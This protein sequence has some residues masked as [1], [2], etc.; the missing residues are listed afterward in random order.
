MNVTAILPALLDRSRVVSLI[1]FLMVIRC[2]F[3]LF[4]LIWLSCVKRL[5][6]A[7]DLA[8]NYSLI[9]WFDF[10][11]YCVVCTIL[12]MLWRRPSIRTQTF[13]GKISTTCTTSLVSS[14][15]TSSSL[16]LTKRSQE[17][18][19][20][21]NI[22][23]CFS[24]VRVL[25]QVVLLM[26]NTMVSWNHQAALEGTAQ[27]PSYVVLSCVLPNAKLWTVPIMKR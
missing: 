24:S 2:T 21:L 18:K 16:A 4:K 12:H 9:Q 20:L 3:V 14:Q 15:L 25:T 19:L 17:H 26:K 11:Y 5:M 1:Q 13:T 8:L 6:L 7:G 22:Y 27:V 23:K 10:S